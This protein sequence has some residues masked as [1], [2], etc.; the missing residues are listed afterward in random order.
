MLS[1]LQL[2]FIC[3]YFSLLNEPLLLQC[4]DNLAHT[5]QHLSL[6]KNEADVEFFDDSPGQQS[7]IFSAIF[8]GST[9][10]AYDYN[11]MYNW[12]GWPD[13]TDT[14]GDSNHD[15]NNADDMGMMHFFSFDEMAMVAQMGGIDIKF[16]HD[17][18]KW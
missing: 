4:L 16:K 11:T 6:E 15:A 17:A 14:D 10:G 7:G 2:A 5:V 1:P 12:L 9:N 8:E 3:K 18:T 13:N